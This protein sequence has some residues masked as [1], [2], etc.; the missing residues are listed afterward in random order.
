M[1]YQSLSL[2][3]VPEQVIM[4]ADARAGAEVGPSSGF[5]SALAKMVRLALTPEKVLE[6]L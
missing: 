4:G 5:S 3:L 6:L 1:T 2:E